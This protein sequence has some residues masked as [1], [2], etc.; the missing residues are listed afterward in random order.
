MTIARHLKQA[1]LALLLLSSLGALQSAYA[2][3]T[4]AGT[5]ISNTATVNYSV[6]GVAQTAITSAPVAFV[7][8]NRVDLT[9]T[10]TNTAAV[11]ANPGQ[12]AVVTT[13]TVTNTGNAIQS[14]RL[15]ATDITTAVFGNNDTLNGLTLSTAVD[16]NGNGTYEAGTD[17][18]GNLGDIA[19][20]ASPTPVRVFVLATVPL[21]ATNGQFASVRLQVQAAAAGSAGATL[22]TETSGADTAGV[23]IVFADAARDA[24]EAADSQYTIESALLTVTKTV[25]V[26]SDPFNNT[27]NPKAIPGAVVEYTITVNNGGTVAATDV[28]VTDSIPANTAYVAGSMLRNGAGVTDSSSDGDNASAAGT[29]VS[30]IAVTIPSVAPAGSANVRFRVTVQ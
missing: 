23:D 2:V 29:P 20:A 8:D 27:T 11:V 28:A 17:V 13:F 7:V 4:T 24:S 5:S 6:G 19:P 25:S 21:S 16:T 18:I 14:Y 26:I 15:T 22:L 1:S 12:T 3:G 10:T 30:S 9:V